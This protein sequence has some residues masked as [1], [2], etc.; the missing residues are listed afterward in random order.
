MDEAQLIEK[1][2]RVEN[3]FAGAATPGERAAAASA[4]DRMRRRLEE[5]QRSDPAV[6]Y[7]F[8]LP[9]VWSRRLLLALLRRYGIRPYRYAGQRHTTVMVRV[10]RRFVEETLWPEFQEL[11]RVLHAYLSETTERVIREGLDADSSEA[12]ER[13]ALP[14][15]GAP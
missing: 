3:L 1:L 8:A 9:H 5:V 2:R 4:L 10:S 12:E 11:D 14:A 6:E 13:A 15:A 7:K